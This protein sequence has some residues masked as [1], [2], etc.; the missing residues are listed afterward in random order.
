MTLLSPEEPRGVGGLRWEAGRAGAGLSC[1][2]PGRRVSLR[3][4][5]V[6]T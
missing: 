3:E 5:I 6:L 1:L 2:W 4:L